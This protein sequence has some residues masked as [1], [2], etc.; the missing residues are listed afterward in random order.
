MPYDIV[1]PALGMA[2]D[3]GL[4]VAW[5]KSQGDAVEA[6]DVLLEVETDKSVMEVP[7]G[8]EGYITEILADEQAAVPVGAVIAVISEE[9]PDGPAPREP[10][11]RDAPPQ[12]APDAETEAT[13]N[14]AAVEDTNRKEAPSRSQAIPSESDLILASPKARRIAREEGLELSRLTAHG[15]PQPYHVADLETLRALSVEPEVAEAKAA[16]PIIAFNLH[17]T[18]K[19]PAEGLDEFIAWI[20]N[21]GGIDIELK[22]FWLRFA[23]E[24]YRKATN[25]GEMAVIVETCHLKI[26]DGRF[27]DAD[28][29]RLSQPVNY[30]GD[31]AP[32]LVIRDFTSSPIS[33][34]TSQAA[35]APVITIG[36]EGS[37]FA[38][39]LDYRDD[40]LSEL[41]AFEFVEYLVEK[42]AD[43]LQNL[44]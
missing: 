26:P 31:S 34:A 29:S 39:S 10:K 7:A 2:Q 14:K 43:P 32:N 15:H 40:Q 21:D 35:D 44:V 12:A 6:D 24:A 18:A 9:K 3:T 27:I 11:R 17:I 22:L 5:R 16:S 20:R 36:R 4:I 13:S 41:Q 33:F 23:T 28:R 19:A 37:E 42:L 30:E 1:M 8:R 25:I 38:I